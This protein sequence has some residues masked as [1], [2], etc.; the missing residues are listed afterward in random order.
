MFKTSMLLHLVLFPT[1]LLFGEEKAEIDFA[2]EILPILSDK[3]YA[4]H[5]PDT[6]KKIW[7]GWI[8]R[9]WPK[10]IL[11]IIMRLIPMI[12]RKANCS[13]G[14]WMRMTPCHR[15]ILAK[16]Y[17]RKKRSHPPM[18][19]FRCRVRRSLVVCPANQGRG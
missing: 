18:G 14:S 10:K 9:N 15:K 5:G 11:G 7:L 2:R 12:W 1:F 4:C 17:R 6:K 19:T 13:T 3:C 16:R 8:S